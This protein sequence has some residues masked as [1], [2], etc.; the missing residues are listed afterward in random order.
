MFHRAERG[1]NLVAIARRDALN[2]RFLGVKPG[3]DRAGAGARLLAD[4]LH[5]GAVKA[6]AGEAA[7]RR[8]QNMGAALGLLG[9]GELGHGKPD[10]E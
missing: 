7:F 8:I 4:V 3:V 9:V 2:Q 6:C 1:Q 5:G 10:P